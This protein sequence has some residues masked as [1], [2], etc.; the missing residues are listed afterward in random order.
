[1]NVSAARRLGCL[2]HLLGNIWGLQVDQFVRCQC[3]DKHKD[4]QSN[5]PSTEGARLVLGLRIRSIWF[6]VCHGRL[7]PQL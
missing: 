7:R 5:V 4:N 2:Q 6:L 1:M 3:E